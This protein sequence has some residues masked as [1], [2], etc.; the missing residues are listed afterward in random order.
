MEGHYTTVQ[1]EVGRKPALFRP[2]ERF[3]KELDDIEFEKVPGRAPQTTSA[4][5]ANGL[6]LS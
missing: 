1:C 2:D 5:D 3:E 4:V 6:D